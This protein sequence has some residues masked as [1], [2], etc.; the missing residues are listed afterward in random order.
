MGDPLRVAI[1][2]GASVFHSRRG[3]RLLTVVALAGPTLMAS[4]SFAGPASA[5]PPGIKCSTLTGNINNTVTLSGCTG[6]TGG[7]SMP[8][9][10]GSFA[11]GGPIPWL[12][13]KTTT[14]TNSSSSTETDGTEA[15][16]CSTP[17]ETEFESTGKV[18]A[19]TTGSTTVG[20]KV[21]S[22]ACVKLPPGNGSIR[23]EPGSKFKIKGS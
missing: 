7:G 4:A 12:N 22:E 3:F 5:A 2:K 18:T 15:K 20:A 14:V 8:I 23:N 19:D 16:K 6:N 10:A 11:S 21:K 17:A 13:G 9:S 1:T